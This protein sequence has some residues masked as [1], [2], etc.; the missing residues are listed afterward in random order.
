MRNTKIY[1]LIAFVHKVHLPSFAQ[2]LR[3]HINL[4]TIYRFI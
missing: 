4:M 1:R 3:R 2:S